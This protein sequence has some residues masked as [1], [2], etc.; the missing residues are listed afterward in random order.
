MVEYQQIEKIN[1]L[2]KATEIKGKNYV[3]VNQ[4]IKGFRMLYP[5]GFI[6]TQLISMAEGICVMSA[7]VGY[8]ENGDKR[9][10]GTGT[11]YEKETSSFINKT[12]YVENCVPLNTQ[13]LTEDGWKYYY[14][15]KPGDMVYTLNMDTE[16]IELSE[17]TRVNIYKDKPI[18]EMS[19]SRFKVR[20]TN[21]HKWVVRT[22]HKPIH[23]VETDK[24]T[25]SM[26]I[27][28]AVEQ[29]VIGSKIGKKLG[30][31]MC[32]CEV[33]NIDGM[34]STA[35]IRQSKYIDE[36][37]ELFGE[38]RKCK[39]YQESWMDS[40]EWTVPAEEVRKILGAFRMANYKD[41]PSAMAKADIADV[42]GCFESMMLADGENRGFSSTYYEL[43][44][45]IQI[46][47]ARLGIATTFITERMMEK[48]TRPIY[49]IGIKKTD[50][51][52]FSELQVKN[53]PPQD[54]WC[55][56]TENGTWIMRQDG[57]VTVTSNCETSAVG[58]ALG[59]AGFGIDA[60]IA[61]AEEVINAIN[62]QEQM[63]EAEKTEKVKKEKVSANHVKALE[64]K[65]TNENVPKDLILE[66]YKVKDLKDLTNEMYRNMMDNWDKVL[67]K[68]RKE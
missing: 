7:E 50:G 51:A 44:E 63:K 45:A 55:P 62:N 65:L 10:L 18:V 47:C 34:A 68:S 5:E 56:T 11:A 9:I 6:T 3:E 60:S 54:V 19:S 15:I 17:L 26:K 57:F 4:R 46:M 1:S 13:I 36:V 48:S 61:S 12:S 67:E 29:N 20:C 35:F 41:L 28:Q 25:N 53:I 2:L 49:T 39:K 64:S 23:K 43:I 37:K 31:L 8:Y 14:Q 27:I 38:G 58:R 33:N 16:K 32:D 66:L 59:M 24:L 30:W 42:A 40:Y 22:Q 52:W 21:Q